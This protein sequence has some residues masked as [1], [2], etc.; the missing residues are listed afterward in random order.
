MLKS[1]LIRFGRAR[2]Q[3]GM[4]AEEAAISRKFAAPGVE[5]VTN[6]SDETDAGIVARVKSDPAAFAPL[7][8]RYSGPVFGY[9]LRR[10]RDRD[11]ADDATSLIFERGTKYLL[12]LQMPR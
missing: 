11:A 12:H 8:A 3:D 5:R 10:L 7:Y 6:E 1:D 2:D 9:C 4:H